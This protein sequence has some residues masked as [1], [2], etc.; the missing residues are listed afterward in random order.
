MK[1]LKLVV[2]GLFTLLSVSNI[3]AQDE[4]NPW[5][6]GF[7]VN[8]VDFIFEPVD[9]GF[10][11]KDLLGSTEDWNFSPLTSR[12]SVS[13]YFDKGFSVSLA[14]SLNKIEIIEIEND[15]DL[16]YYS[17][18]ASALYDIN[19]LIGDTGWFDPYAHL[20][21]SYV[22]VDS[23]GE[24]MLTFGVG[25][26]FWFNDNFGLNF[27][28]GAKHGFANNV[29]KHWQYSLGFLIK[30][31]GIDTDGDAV[32]DKND[33]CPKVPGLM[34]FNGCPDADGDGIKDSDDACPNV[35]G[36]VAMN[37]CP[38]AD[39]DNVADKEDMCPNVKGTKA[40]KGC[41][42]TD[43]DGVIDKNDKCATDAG[44]MANGGCPWLDTDGDSILDKD[45]KCPE[46]AG[47]ASEGGCREI[48]SNEAKMGMDSFAEAIL[49]NLESASFQRGVEKDLGGMVVIINEFPEA[50]FAIRG[51]TDISGSVSG[52]LKLSNARAN[53]V[54]DYLVENGIDR[55]RLTTTGFGQKSPI[56]SNKTRAGRVQNRR[57]EVKVTN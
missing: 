41:P 10:H 22:S 42:D 34:E 53:A 43:G 54:L 19:N 4:N 9:D 23:K 7:G 45:D 57:V 47:I 12:L 15:S 39:A 20:G 2:M 3:S 18:D 38:D 14:G 28:S 24:G 37:G 46:V 55:A 50:N 31:G 32:Y 48:I 17:L 35:A 49:F 44:P 25:A 29:R 8:V 33:A 16:L 30:F 36:L 1:R 51:Y 13:K 5:V 40:N 52:N 6:V 26:N 21:G 27:H 11:Y 56:A